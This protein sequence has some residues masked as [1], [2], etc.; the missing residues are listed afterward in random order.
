MAV[1]I[2]QNFHNIKLANMATTYTYESVD[3]QLSKIANSK[4]AAKA[5]EKPIDTLRKL[6]DGGLK[7]VISLL[8]LTPFIPKKWKEN[9]VKFIDLIDV[10][11]I[12]VEL[13]V[14]EKRM[15]FK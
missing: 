2:R 10:L 14:E 9:L 3:K 4:P 11:V 8:A 5:K 1:T 15:S 13:P 7:G 6:W 12:K